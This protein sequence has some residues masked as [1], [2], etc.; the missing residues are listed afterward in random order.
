MSPLLSLFSTSNPCTVHYTAHLWYSIQLVGG[1]VPDQWCCWR[2]ELLH[3][4]PL[5]PQ[6]GQTYSREAA[7][8]YFA[9]SSSSSSISSSVDIHYKHFLTFLRVNLC[10]FVLLLSPCNFRPYGA[11][12]LYIEYSIMFWPPAPC[13][14]SFIFD[15]SFIR[16]LLLSVYTV[17]I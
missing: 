12:E 1:R 6:P 13:H 3:I 11:W 9:P 10:H 17:E 5:P 14:T 4:S 2:E 16:L 8:I 15:C 7:R